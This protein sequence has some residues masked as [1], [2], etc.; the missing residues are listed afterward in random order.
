MT[1]SDTHF[2][3]IQ[4]NQGS[5]MYF[6]TVVI[7][8]VRN[9]C[10]SHIISHYFKW[11]FCQ[12]IHLNGGRMPCDHIF[13][14]DHTVGTW[15]IWRWWIISIFCCNKLGQNVSLCTCSRSR[16]IQGRLQWRGNSVFNLRQWS[17]G[18][19]IRGGGPYVTTHGL[20]LISSIDNSSFLLKDLVDFV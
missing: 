6:L 9:V 16:N 15:N 14:L 2:F 20:V 19:I 10:T 8:A 7:L 1:L 13:R 17:F 5:F 3:P 4:L 11:N 18:K 12:N